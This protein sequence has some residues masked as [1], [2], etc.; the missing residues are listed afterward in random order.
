MNAGEGIDKREPSYT[1]G[2]NVIGATAI[3]NSMEFP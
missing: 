1:A 2:E 3:E